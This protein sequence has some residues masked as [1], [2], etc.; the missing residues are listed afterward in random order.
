VVAHSL[1]KAT[2]C[3]AA[4]DGMAP[5]VGRR[6]STAVGEAG[7]DGPGCQRPTGTDAL[8]PPGID[9]PRGSRGGVTFTRG[10]RALAR[11]VSLGRGRD[12]RDPG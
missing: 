3:D 7:D 10:C 6:V 11:T 1:P 8:R 5:R 2:H 9:P 12:H 4:G